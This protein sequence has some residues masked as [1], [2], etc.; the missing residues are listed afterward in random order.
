MRKITSSILAGAL[1]LAVIVPSVSYAA[2]NKSAEMKPNFPNRGMHQAFNRGFHERDWGNK[3]QLMEIVNQ[4]APELTDE[5]ESVFS[6][7]QE[8]KESKLPQINDETKH[9]LDEIRKQVE[10]GT[11][12]KEE[13]KTK[14]K[15]LRIGIPFKERGNRIPPQI[16]DET[17]QKLDEIRKQ[18][19]EGTLTNEEANEKMK[20]LGI[21]LPFKGK[22]DLERPSF[23][24]G[25]KQKVEANRQIY[26]QLKEAIDT[27]DKAKIEEQL[28]EILKNLK[29]KVELQVK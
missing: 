18:V 10:G 6:L 25:A 20:E 15:E 21:N 5:F 3:E 27:G 16:D 7:L 8:G 17:K 4:Y 24:K 22:G 2:V 13:A 11:L 14:M 1:A 9:K 23:G 29:N 12:T 19:E 26:Q 28:M